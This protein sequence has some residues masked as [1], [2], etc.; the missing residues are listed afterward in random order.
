MVFQEPKLEQHVLLTGHHGVLISRILDHAGPCWSMMFGSMTI[1]TMMWW[2]T[3]LLD[4]A[5]RS[6][7]GLDH[8]VRIPGGWDHTV[9]IFRIWCSIQSSIEHDSSSVEHP[10]TICA[11]RTQ[12]SKVLEQHGTSWDKHTMML[13]MYEICRILE[14]DGPKLP[15]RQ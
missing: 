9:A 11:S 14:Q 15:G 2:V 12:W 5:V 7:F 8:V 10:V 1:Y 6:Q 4:H 3:W 13:W